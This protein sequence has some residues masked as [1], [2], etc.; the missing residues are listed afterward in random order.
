L[1]T[2]PNPFD[3]YFTLQIS[4]NTPVRSQGLIINTLGQ[5]VERFEMIDGSAD[6]LGQNLDAGF[7]ILQVETESG[8]LTSKI[9]KN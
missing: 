5:V 4:G 7:Y 3:E 6:M 2:A 1:S 9:T 8:V